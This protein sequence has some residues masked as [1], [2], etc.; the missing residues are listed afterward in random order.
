MFNIV[1]KVLLIHQKERKNIPHRKR[2]IFHSNS[3]LFASQTNTTLDA[4]T[5]TY[6]YSDGLSVLSVL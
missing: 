4:R 5:Y 6:V 2:G 3:C 1:I